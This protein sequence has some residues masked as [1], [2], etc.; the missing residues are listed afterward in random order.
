MGIPDEVYQ[1]V[2]RAEEASEVADELETLYLLSEK[3]PEP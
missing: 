1:E 2:T 3:A